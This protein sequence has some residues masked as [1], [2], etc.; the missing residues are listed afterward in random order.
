[1]H[2]AGLGAMNTVQCTGQHSAIH[3]K[4]N[5][6][7]AWATTHVSR[8]QPLDARGRPPRELA[9]HDT[10]RGSVWSMHHRHPPRVGH[11]RRRSSDTPV[12]LF[13]HQD[14]NQ[15]LYD[16]RRPEAPWM[17]L[18]ASRDSRIV[19]TGP[20]ILKRRTVQGPCTAT[21]CRCNR[22]RRMRIR[23]W[24]LVGAGGWWWGR[25]VCP[26]ASH[27]SRDRRASAH[28]MTA[29]RWY[30]GLTDPHCPAGS[31]ADAALKVAGTGGALRH[32]SAS[33]AVA[34][35]AAEACGGVSRWRAHMQL[36]R[37]EAAQRTR[38]CATRRPASVV[39]CFVVAA[40]LASTVDHV[41]R[42]Q[43]TTSQYNLPA[44]V[45]PG[46]RH[47]VSMPIQRVRIILGVRQRSS[48]LDRVS[49]WGTWQGTKSTPG[50][51]MHVNH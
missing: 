37:S 24:R 35:A 8:D 13:W 9:D 12:R 29:A 1:M 3:R 26:H 7:A 18:M 45:T 25:P 47:A 22:S 19:G 50:R 41:K 30:N 10:L 42:R 44:C 38:A 4:R 49:P 31:A 23:R 17:F 48:P 32:P 11:R 40:A 43:H 15:S 34:A 16:E 46:T 28:T 21:A 14:N 6:A 27:E 51:S 5:A 33:A 39:A 2:A 20:L 36:K